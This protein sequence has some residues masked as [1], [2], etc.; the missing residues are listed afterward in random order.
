MIKKLDSRQSRAK[1]KKG[2]LQE[3]PSVLGAL[4]TLPRQSGPNWALQ[5]QQDESDASVVKGRMYTYLYVT[6]I[7]SSM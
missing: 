3:K 4:S 7:F 1:G 2:Q 5:L 6:S